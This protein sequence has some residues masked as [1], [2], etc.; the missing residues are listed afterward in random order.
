MIGERA[1][2]ARAAAAG[3]EPHAVSARRTVEY[4]RE[5][6]IDT[7]RRPASASR[8][9]TP[10]K[11]R[12]SHGVGVGAWLDV[13]AAPSGVGAATPTTI[14]LIGRPSVDV[15]AG[16]TGDKPAHGALAHSLNAQD[17]R[18]R[19]KVLTGSRNEPLSPRELFSLDPPGES[20]PL[21][22]DGAP[23]APRRP[24]PSSSPPGTVAQRRRLLKCVQ[25]DDM[26][27][28]Y[29]NDLLVALHAEIQAAVSTLQRYISNSMAAVLT[30][31]RREFDAIH[32]DVATERAERI[33]GLVSEEV[34]LLRTQVQ[35]D[36]TPFTGAI[37]SF[38]E[39]L[40]LAME[41]F[42][43]TDEKQSAAVA[44][45][46]CLMDAIKD[47]QRFTENE[48]SVSRHHVEKCVSSLTNEVHALRDKIDFRE[49]SA[50]LHWSIQEASPTALLEKVSDA[51]PAVSAELERLAA[52]VENLTNQ[53]PEVDLEPI[54]Q[55]VKEAE[56]ARI[57]Q[58]GVVASNL[59]NLKETVLGS[60]QALS[61]LQQDVQT[62]A[63]SSLEA[64]SNVQSEVKGVIAGMADNGLK[65]QKLREDVARA[66]ATSAD[67]AIGVGLEAL[68]AQVQQ[69]LR[70][71][72][73]E[74]A[75]IR[76]GVFSST[77]SVLA[78][79]V[80]QGITAELADMR[81]AFASCGRASPLLAQSLT[82]EMSQTLTNITA[83][84]QNDLRAVS[85]E[86]NQMRYWQTSASAEITQ[87]RSWQTE[88]RRFL[89]QSA[90]EARVHSGS[91]E[92]LAALTQLQTRTIS[93]FDAAR[94]DD[95]V[96][97]SLAQTQTRILGAIEVSHV[98]DRAPELLT[99][100]GQMQTKLLGS[101][102]I[103]RGVA[104]S[105]E[106]L[107]IKEQVQAHAKLLAVVEDR[108]RNGSDVLA[109]IGQAQGRLLNDIE[110]I[111]LNTEIA[112]KNRVAESDKLDQEIAQ[113]R[114]D[115][116]RLANL[117]FTPV[118]NAIRT[119]I[120]TDC[121]DVFSK[122]LHDIREDV[123]NFRGPLQDFTPI[124]DPMGGKN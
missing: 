37:K 10:G 85:S 28:T 105:P 51:M 110:A 7:S 106:I 29:R 27:H 82:V 122:D 99:A 94:V 34:A 78:Q 64:L 67:S 66:A 75:E 33:L 62:T 103:P 50:A 12:C 31:A 92:V 43:A 56:R 63:A 9:S 102:D 53:R 45:S 52:K 57:S 35:V 118:V 100:I 23:N 2:D 93:A 49:M 83:S 101:L 38:S 120:K 26:M 76:A 121:F 72:K 18:C 6:Q 19:Q 80:I 108:T 58:Y 107:T 69:D 117:D 68:I 1:F 48:S 96:I 104:Q 97:A 16:T 70:V 22:H 87:M 77:R 71:L 79:S 95:T 21:P 55:I 13:V 124:A 14:R 32:S 60:L 88:T 112:Q 119:H 17:E 73:P 111:K 90:D 8:K 15:A 89:E 25:P 30:D 81:E 123:K 24:R 4:A 47:L 61:R 114:M 44:E 84:L 5:C 59:T 20:R 98:V 65:L 46:V 11:P 39:E 113:I 42:A 116:L 109:A 40:K 115:V 91:A 54:V 74:I 36:I 86:I 41:Q 3:Y